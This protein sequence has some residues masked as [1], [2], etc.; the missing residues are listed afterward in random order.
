MWII[1]LTVLFLLI[2]RSITNKAR[3][4][5]QRDLNTSRTI[6]VKEQTAK[7]EIPPQQTTTL[8]SVEMQ[9]PKIQ[10]PRSAETLTE[11]R[12]KALYKLSTKIL[13]DDHVDLA[14]TRKLRS[15]LRRYPESQEDW[16]T[17][18]IFKL[19]E[20]VLEDRV[21][22]HDEALEVFALLSEYC[23]YFD[24]RTA[25]E[26]AKIQHTKV[27]KVQARSEKEKAREELTETVYTLG[28]E[29]LLGQLEQNQLY[30]MGYKDSKGSISERHIIFKK[31]ETNDYGQQ[32]VKAICLLRNSLRT[33]RADRIQWMCD[34]ETG[35]ALV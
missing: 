13:E 6:E 29:V 30:A 32:Y 28:N 2:F 24:L 26:N 8:A 20:S 3:E 11:R 27:E 17:K 23:E 21:L 22:D 7:P 5:K 1:V 19:V 15:W 4:D 9:E 14:E 34:V 33:F 16:R 25:S 12:I 31:S 10:E 35:E 18:Q